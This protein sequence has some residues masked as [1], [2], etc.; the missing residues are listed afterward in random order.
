MKKT[1]AIMVSVIAMLAVYKWQHIK[2]VDDPKDSPIF[3]QR[4]Q[5]SLDRFQ[6]NEFPVR[7]DRMQARRS[8]SKTSP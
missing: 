3:Q 1:I 8:S 4:L 5:S 6:K 2:P 7:E